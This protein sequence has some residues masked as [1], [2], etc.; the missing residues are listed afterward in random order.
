[1]M[2]YVGWESY[3]HRRV[4]NRLSGGSLKIVQKFNC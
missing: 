2:R 4:R 1:M 3:P